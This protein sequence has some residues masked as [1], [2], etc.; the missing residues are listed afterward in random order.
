MER[1][2]FDSAD[3][4]LMLALASYR[5]ACCLGLQPAEARKILQARDSGAA[6]PAVEFRLRNCLLLVRLFRALENVFCGNLR[7]GQ[8]W[9]NRR[10]ALLKETPRKLMESSHGL[11]LVVDYLESLLK[12][13]Q[14][15]IH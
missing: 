11:A 10:N 5:A 15:T 13:G 2:T 1:K 8:E 6:E 7:E 9:L 12:S 3:A 14:R 4:D